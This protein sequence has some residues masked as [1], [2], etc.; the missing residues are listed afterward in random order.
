MIRIECRRCGRTYERR[1]LREA[2]VCHTRSHEPTDLVAVMPRSDAAGKRWKE[3]VVMG[4]AQISVRL[5]LGRRSASR[6]A[7]TRLRGSE[8]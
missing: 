4:S 6:V 7:R 1:D 3:V 5:P 2:I 8:S